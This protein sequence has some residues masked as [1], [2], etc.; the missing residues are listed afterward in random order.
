MKVLYIL[1]TI[2]PVHP[3]KIRCIQEYTTDIS[4]TTLLQNIKSSTSGVVDGEYRHL[5]IYKVMLGKY[6]NSTEYC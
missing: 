2:D 4:L 3:S 1:T 6:N 5:S